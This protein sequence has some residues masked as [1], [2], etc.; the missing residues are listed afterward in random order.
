VYY[1]QAWADIY[2]V[3][4]QLGPGTQSCE[5][6]GDPSL[7]TRFPSASHSIETVYSIEYMDR[8]L[9]SYLLVALGLIVTKPNYHAELLRSMA[10]CCQDRSRSSMPFWDVHFWGS[11]SR[12][13]FL[14]NL[15]MLHGTPC[16]GLPHLS[17]YVVRHC[18][19]FFSLSERHG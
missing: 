7:L 19:D 17:H 11:I 15:W 2:L 9:S 6:T 13:W 5:G 16:S 12:D 10:L 8:E 4:K 1:W 18:W 3:A 14:P